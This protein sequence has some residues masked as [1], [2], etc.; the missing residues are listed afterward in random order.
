MVVER[1]GSSPAVESG[2]PPPAGAAA[3]PARRR[4]EARELEEAEADG[5]PPISYGRGRSRS[6]S[7]TKVRPRTASRSRRRRRRL[8]SAH[9]LLPPRAQAPPARFDEWRAAA[10]LVVLYCV[11]GVPLGLSM[12]SV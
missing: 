12:G 11:Q 9:P 1:R 5:L 2:L 7:P 8:G 3:P 10:L 4:T 6:R